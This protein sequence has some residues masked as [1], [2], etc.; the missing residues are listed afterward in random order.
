GCGECRQAVEAA[1]PQLARL[2]PGCDPLVNALH[3]LASGGR[4]WL[5]P[6]HL[7]AAQA[8]RSEPSAWCRLLLEEGLLLAGQERREAPRLA[9]E[10]ALF[11][12]RQLPQ[13]EGRD[14][15]A[16]A[17]LCDAEARR[18]YG[19]AEQRQALLARARRLL[20]EGSGAPEHEARWH[21]TAGRASRALGRHAE[22]IERQQRA[23]ELCTAN[24]LA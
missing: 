17:Q 2:E 3:H 9:T 18:L 23:L 16:L 20:G 7:A 12:G 4:E 11:A 10:M 22:A 13:A 15:L 19:Q 14:L 6:G 21:A 1:A 8:A 5:S 24:G